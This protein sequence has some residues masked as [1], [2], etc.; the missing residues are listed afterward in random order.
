MS[1]EAF[2]TS[3]GLATPEASLT[4]QN[5]SAHAEAIMA[6]ADLDRGRAIRALS[7]KEA[8]GGA[9]SSNVGTGTDGGA[10]PR[11]SWPQLALPH[12]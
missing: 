1:G 3:L 8:Q 5:A 2:L 12:E 11:P 7:T 9:D 10:T 4:Q 6:A